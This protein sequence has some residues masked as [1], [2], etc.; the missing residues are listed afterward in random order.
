MK[1]ISAIIG[2]VLAGFLLWYFIIKPYDYLVTFKVKTS[3]GTINQTI[4]L[5]NTSI[6]NL[7]PV[8]QENIANLSQQIEVNDSIHN[9]K[10]SISSVNDSISKVNVYVTDKEHSFANRISIPFGT[11]DFE[12]RIEYSVTDFIAKLKEHLKKIKVSVAGIDTTRSTYAAYIS[13]KGLQIEKARG[14]MQNYSLLTSILSAEN[15]TMNGTPFV[16]ITNWNTQNDSIAYNFCFPV[17]KSDS[18]PVDSRIQ[19][20]QY[21]GAKALKATYNGNYITSDRAWYALVDYAEN[22]DIKI[23]KNPLEV[24][25]SNPNFGGDELQWKAEIFMP[26]KD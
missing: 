3:A 18:L 11:T 9:Y 21:N 6:A 13:M 16:E 26:I 1:K 2:F 8:K 10:W 25:Y 19:Y 12:K 15:I 24:F 5:W 22:N 7:N 17:I 23:D 14:M 4:K 20:K